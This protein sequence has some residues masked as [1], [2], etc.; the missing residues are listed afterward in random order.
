[1]SNPTRNP[2]PRAALR[3]VGAVIVTITALS[4][5]ALQRGLDGVAHRLQRGQADLDQARAQALVDER[6]MGNVIT[7][8]LAMIVFGVIAIVALG[9]AI[10]TLGGNVVNWVTK[11]LGV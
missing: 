7:D 5:M 9:A 2:G 11:Q 1:M 6:E 8:N 4:T 10:A 3:A